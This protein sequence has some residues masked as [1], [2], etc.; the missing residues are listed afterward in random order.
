MKVNELATFI[1][2]K[3]G[4]TEN[5]ITCTHCVT[6]LRFVLKDE[7]KADTEALKK[8]DGILNV[9]KG[10]GQYQVVIGPNVTTVYAQVIELLPKNEKAADAPQSGEKKSALNTF[11]EGLSS[12]FAPCITALTAGGLLKAIMALL[13]ALKAV[14][15]SSQTYLLFSYI[16]DSAFYFLPFLL[17]Y[18]T[19]KRFKGNVGL[20]LMM[21]GV[22]QYPSLAGLYTD[23]EGAAQAVKFFGII[24]VT[25]V[26]YA[27]TVAPII[28]TVLV[29]C[30]I[31]HFLEKVSPQV[32]KFFVVPVGTIVAGGILGLTLLGPLGSFISNGVAAFVTAL[33]NTVPWLVPTLNGAFMPFL[34]MTGTHLAMMPLGVQAITSLGIDRVIGPGG[35]ASNLAQGGAALAVSVAVKDEN[36]KRNAAS[37]GL[38]ALCGITEPALYGC[39]LKLQYPLIGTMIGGGCGGLFLGLTRAGRYAMGPSSLLMLPA[40]IGGDSMTNFYCGCIGAVIAIVVSFVVTFVLVRAKQDEIEKML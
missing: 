8:Q 24:P 38:T 6:R 13:V 3:V 2:E 31:Q 28:L 30:Y 22:F 17:A 26:N 34:V 11:L 33:N 25:K 10:N 20:A 35:L 15:T 16:A 40:Y 4:G 7:A 19:A 14:D 23:A 1:V 9:V 39:N 32:I 18:G 12:C 21:A 36:M 5:V 37:M 29:M 27:S